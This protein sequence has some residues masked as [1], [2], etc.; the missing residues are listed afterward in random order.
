MKTDYNN[1]NYASPSSGGINQENINF[2]PSTSS[3]LPLLLNNHDTHLDHA[4]QYSGATSNSTSN[5]INSPLLRVP[6]NNV[7]TNS[8]TTSSA[9][10]NNNP[11]QIY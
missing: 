5:N 8:T 10:S 2:P 6:N 7:P 1:S 3:S 11:F 4:Q 9:T